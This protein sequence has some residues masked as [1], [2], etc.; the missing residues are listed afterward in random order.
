LTRLFFPVFALLLV[1]LPRVVHA[2]AILALAVDGDRSPDGG[3]YLGSVSIFAL[4]V[5]GF[6]SIPA[7][8]LIGCGDPA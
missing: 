3:D 8:R 5:A 1:L 2:Q 6:L 7:A 4:S